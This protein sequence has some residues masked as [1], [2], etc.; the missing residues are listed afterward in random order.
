MK[1]IALI[2]LGLISAVWA[3]GPPTDNI[4][5]PATTSSSTVGDLLLAIQMFLQKCLVMVREL[6]WSVLKVIISWAQATLVLISSHIIE[7]VKAIL[8][9]LQDLIISALIW[10]K[11]HAVVVLVTGAVLVATTLIVGKLLWVRHVEAVKIA[12]D[13]ETRST[14]KVQ[15]FFT[16][17]FPRLARFLKLR[18]N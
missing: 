15:T 1:S 9:V 5:T 14:T 18:T 8:S 2:L 17:N 16:T 12:E 11:N 3:A 13:H 7:L 10:A 6:T 4:T